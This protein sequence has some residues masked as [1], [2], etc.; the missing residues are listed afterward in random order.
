MERGSPLVICVGDDAASPDEIMQ[1]S[2]CHW[3]LPNES[4]TNITLLPLN[5]VRNSTALN[6]FEKIN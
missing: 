5:L 6:L 4:P 1:I 2:D 3:F